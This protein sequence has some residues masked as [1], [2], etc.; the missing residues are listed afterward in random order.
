MNIRMTMV[1]QGRCAEKTL[2]LLC[3][4]FLR[5]LPPSLPSFAVCSQL[6]EYG[7]RGRY[8][9]TAQS[10]V[11]EEISGERGCVITLLQHRVVKMVIGWPSNLARVIFSVMS[12]SKKDY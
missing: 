1:T 6:M 7:S 10:A 9:R 11:E 5:S 8:G 12:V 2:M 4:T 3:F